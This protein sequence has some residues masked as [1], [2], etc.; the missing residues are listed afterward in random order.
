MSFHTKKINKHHSMKSTFGERSSYSRDTQKSHCLGPAAEKTLRT[1]RALMASTCF[2]GFL[3]PPNPY[4]LSPYALGEPLKKSANR[5]PYR[6][7][8]LHL[9]SVQKKQWLSP[10]VIPISIIQK[11]RSDFSTLFVSGRLQLCNV[12]FNELIK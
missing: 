6:P 7:S 1:G 12:G 5:F 2:R 11:W 3:N 4:P 9:P 8:K 10:S